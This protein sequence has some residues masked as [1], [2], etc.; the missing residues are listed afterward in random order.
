MSS[1]AIAEALAFRNALRQQP[2]GGAMGGRQPVAD[3]QDDVLRLARPG[4]VHVPAKFAGF[5][6]VRDADVVDA[7]VPERNVAQEQR[8][9]ILAGLA[10]DKRGGL[11]EDL[12]VVLAVQRDRDL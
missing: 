8:G 1:M 4:I 12:G 6:S 3:E 11:A 2:R 10:F 5:S 7:G 9:L